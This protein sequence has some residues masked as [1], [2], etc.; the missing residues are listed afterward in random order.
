V[1]AKE[2]LQPEALLPAAGAWISGASGTVE[3]TGRVRT[4]KKP[5]A[6]TLDLA[7]RD[8]AFETPLAQVEAVNGTLRVV[9]PQP[10]STPPSQLVSIGR[11]G[12]GLDLVNGLLAL[13]LLP[14][15]AL[16]I[17]KAEWQTL[18]AE[19]LD[20][21][22][23]LALVNLEGL[24]GQ[25]RLDGSLPLTRR[26]DAIEVRGGVLRARPGGW[27]R[28]QPGDRVAGL[29][30]SGGIGIELLLE[31]FENLQV[32]TLELTLD[33]NTNAL[34]QLGLRVVGVNPDFQDG[35]PLHYSLNVESRLA[36]LLR[37]G[38]AAYRIPQVIEERLQEFGEKAEQAKEAQKP[39]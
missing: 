12:F 28:Y 3:A 5:L 31:A 17:E 29:K 20:L 7:A 33:G 8:L 26:R 9:G 1:F 32:E 34:M 13:Q 14:D 27:L 19:D 25:G 23:L 39:K 35:R 4:G 15:G 10:W 37:Q 6:A 24:S 36:D 11:I 2:G 16:S 38:A 21:A 18:E 30:Q 22:Q